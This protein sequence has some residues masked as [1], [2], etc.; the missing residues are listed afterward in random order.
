MEND[1][2]LSLLARNQLSEYESTLL[3]NHSKI[4]YL[5]FIGIFA[6]VLLSRLATSLMRLNLEV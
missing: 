3:C 4:L 2:I 5:V 6:Y 1:R